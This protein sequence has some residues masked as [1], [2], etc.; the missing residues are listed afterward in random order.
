L[1]KPKKR[2]Q[3]ILTTIYINLADIFSKIQT[4]QKVTNGL[5]IAQ[6]WGG[7]PDL[8]AK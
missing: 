6:P 4:R 8:K 7:K 2:T 5:D 1:G 3:N